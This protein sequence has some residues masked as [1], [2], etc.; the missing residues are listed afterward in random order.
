MAGIGG[1]IFVHLEVTL[2]LFLLFLC[3]LAFVFW[4]LDP[5]PCTNALTTSPASI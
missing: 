4:G 2:K 3:E 1:E 5:E